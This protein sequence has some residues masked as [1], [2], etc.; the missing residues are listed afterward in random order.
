M[1]RGHWSSNETPTHGGVPVLPSPIAPDECPQCA[2]RFVSR[3]SLDAHL[4]LDHVVDERGSLTVAD[5]LAT[6]R[7][8][9]RAA[10]G[11]TEQQKGTYD[12]PVLLRVQS[13]V[14]HPWVVATVACV[15][16]LFAVSHV[17]FGVGR[18]LLLWILAGVCAATVALAARGRG[19]L[20]PQ[21]D[22]RRQRP[23]WD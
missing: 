12:R 1:R 13:F 8:G 19:Q 9:P 18:L 2:L 3:S 22:I 20:R 17:G 21:E 14:T 4:R 10:P 7:E 23:P 15:V 6:A 11:P 16:M 5:I